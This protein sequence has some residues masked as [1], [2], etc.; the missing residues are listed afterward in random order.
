VTQ[1]LPVNVEVDKSDG[2]WSV[3]GLPMVL[4]PRHLIT[5]NLSAVEELL[6]V[7]GSASLFHDAGY[8]S[9]RQWCVHQGERH[10]LDGPAVLRHYLEQL[11]R[12]GWGRF[13]FSELDLARGSATV[14]IGNSALAHRSL[15][16]GK[17]GCYLFVAWLE[18]AL[19]HARSELPAAP[20]LGIREM[21]CAADGADECV[22]ESYPRSSSRADGSTT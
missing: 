22:F 13:R 17:T 20:A 7:D 2:H 21:R 18:G 11:S 9:A 8:R 5:N 15:P 12:R 16:S 19:D 3:D 1:G 14:R 4:V 6:G 10:G